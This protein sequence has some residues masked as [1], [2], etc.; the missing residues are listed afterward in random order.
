MKV[1]L[2][3]GANIDSQRM[4]SWANFFSG[5]RIAV[6][7]GRIE[8]WLDQFAPND[9]DVAARIL[10]CV[11]FIP[12]E[13]MANAFRSLLRALSGW[14]K[15]EEL[16]K[17]KWRFIAFSVSAGESGDTM[18]HKFRRANDLD[19]KN[20]N[21]LFIHKS[22][23]FKENL[24]PN[25]TVVFID[26][27]AG[28]GKQACGAWTDNLKEL[29]PGGPNV[30]L[31]LLGSSISARKKIE[32]ETDLKVNPYLELTEKDNI[33]SPVCKHFTRR[34]KETLLSY[35]KKADRRNPKGYG[36]CG[37]V[38]VFAHNCPNN[39]IPILHANH[40]RWEGLF[41]RHD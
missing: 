14:N 4:S 15:N 10:D 3:R 30:F 35:C 24:G 38:I 19:G 7:E 2:H 31:V 23:L 27:F 20:Y 6:T 40:R 33:F 18:L 41:R 5:Y 34:E 25:D 36:D 39:T 21:N 26:D 12:H 1:P 8:R 11:D 16:R 28:T 37:F 13:Q 17:G 29:L 9:C 32:A 22:D